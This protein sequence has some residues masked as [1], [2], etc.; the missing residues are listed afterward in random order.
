MKMKAL[1]YYSW[2]LLA[3]AVFTLNSCYSDD[4]FYDDDNYSQDFYYTSQDLAAYNWVENYTNGDGYD[5]TE[6]ISFSLNRN[7]YDRI[8]V[9]NSNGTVRSDD[10]YNFVWHWLSADQYDMSISY[11]DGTYIYFSQIDLNKNYLSGYFQ[12]DNGTPEAV[13]FKGLN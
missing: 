6:V 3:L 7:G 9:Y 2:I 4:S 11:D 8:T 5:T 12:T 10:S 1:R 13:N